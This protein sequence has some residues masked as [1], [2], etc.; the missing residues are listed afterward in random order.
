MPNVGVDRNRR[1]ALLVGALSSLGVPRDFTEHQW[2]L[3][4]SFIRAPRQTALDMGIDY[5]E[6]RGKWRG[7]RGQKSQIEALYQLA[8]RISSES[9]A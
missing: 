7:S 6:A 9:S 4:E 8:K 1:I 5:P 2:G 3:V